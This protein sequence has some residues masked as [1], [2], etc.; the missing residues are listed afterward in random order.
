[1]DTERLHVGKLAAAA[2]LEGVQPPSKATVGESHRF[3]GKKYSIPHLDDFI[4]F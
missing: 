2:L 1:M 4:R 3:T